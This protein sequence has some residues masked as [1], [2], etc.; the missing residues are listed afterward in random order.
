VNGPVGERMK[1]RYA[2][3]RAHGHFTEK[4]KAA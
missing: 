4:P 2:K 1:Q 3:F